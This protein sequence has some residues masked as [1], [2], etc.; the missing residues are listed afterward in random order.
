MTY[1]ACIFDEKVTFRFV[2]IIKHTLS[3]FLK[4]RSPYKIEFRS[5][6]RVQGFYDDF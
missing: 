4:V 1:M 6:I 5:A 2:H 3:I